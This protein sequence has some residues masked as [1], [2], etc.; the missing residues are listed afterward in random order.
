LAQELLE[1]DNMNELLKD[2]EYNRANGRT[3]LAI[4]NII[5]YLKQLDDKIKAEWQSKT[6]DVAH[7]AKAVEQPK[8]PLFFPRPGAIAYCQNGYLGL[9]TE[10]QDPTWQNNLTEAWVGIHLGKNRSGH[11]KI[12]GAFWHSRNPEVVGYIDELIEKL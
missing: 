9:I 2:A 6:P 4:D 10:K 5:Q 12:F 1:D 8:C 11:G 7:A 3:V